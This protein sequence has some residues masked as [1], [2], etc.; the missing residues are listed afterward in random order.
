MSWAGTILRIDLTTG[1]I[2]KEPTSKYI[3]D[4]IGGAVIGTRI[5]TEEV[6]PDT[7]AYDPKNMLT[8]NTGPLTGT[9]LGNKVLVASKAPHH[10]CRVWVVDHFI[11]VLR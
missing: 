2:A 8:F 3:K 5:F 9:L 4:Y 6:P 1:K 10:C 11:R 7:N